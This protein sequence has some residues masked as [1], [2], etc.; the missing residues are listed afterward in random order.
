MVVGFDS[1]LRWLQRLLRKLRTS[2]PK[3][4]LDEIR[5]IKLELS[6]VLRT[7][8]PLQGVCQHMISNPN[9]GA[10]STMYIEDTQDHI[11]Q[12]A[13]EIRRLIELCGDIGMVH[14]SILIFS[15]PLLNLPIALPLS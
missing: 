10:D 9:I 11:E 8:H 5:G 14:L 1:R 12:A 13:V 7:I 6:D 15:H 3:E 2:F 4:Y